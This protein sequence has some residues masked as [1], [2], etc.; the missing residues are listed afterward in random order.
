MPENRIRCGWCDS[1]SQLYVDYHDHE[2]GVPLGDDIKLFEMLVLEG[3]QAGLS[4]LTVLKKRSNFRTAFDG[5]DPAVVAAYDEQKKDNLLGNALIIR[6]RLKI[7][8]AITNAKVVL[9]LQDE[10]GSFARYLWQFVEFSP[11]QNS[12]AEMGDLPAETE[13]S[14]RISKD[15]KKRGMNFVGPTI[16]YAFMQ[17]IGM[18][19]DHVVSC[20]RYEE[21]GNMAG[22][23]TR[24]SL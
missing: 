20:F 21:C 2:W 16:V 7:D 23:L 10:F 3:M 24:T 12:F 4:W 8:S 18:V 17:S 1:S 15:L 13:F 5:F 14:S 9:Q 22:E 19:N 6:N 11:V